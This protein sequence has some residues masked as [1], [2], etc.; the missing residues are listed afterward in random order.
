MQTYTESDYLRDKA[1]VDRANAYW[2]SHATFARNG[3][4]SMSAD[5]ASHPD[6]A[7]C[8]NGTRGRVESFE[9]AR[10][11]PDR[12]AAYVTNKPDVALWPGNVIG[13]IT[14]RGHWNTSGF[15]HSTKWRQVV[16]RSAWGM[17]YHGREYNT[18]QLVRFRAY[19][20]RL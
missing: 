19:K 14:Y 7:A 16:F 12:F 3:W 10:D 5:L 18:M 17:E 4:S 15:G 1:I 8:D 20:A 2:Q 13:T 6:W 11:K 9:L